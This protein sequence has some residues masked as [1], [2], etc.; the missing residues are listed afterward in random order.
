MIDKKL[1]Y[2]MSLVVLLAGCGESEQKAPESKTTEV[3]K[4][5]ELKIKE[6][7]KEAIDPAIALSDKSTKSALWLAAFNQD[8]NSVLSQKDPEYHIVTASN[9]FNN[10]QQTLEVM[11]S[12][13]EFVFNIS[14]VKANQTHLVKSIDLSTLAHN[15]KG[16]KKADIV[17]DAFEYIQSLPADLAELDGVGAALAASYLNLHQAMAEIGNYFFIK[18]AYSLDD[19]AKA[20][21]LYNNVRAAFLAHSEIKQQFSA[22]YSDSYKEL[23]LAKKSLA[24][25]QGQVIHYNVMESMDSMDEV[26]KLLKSDTLLVEQLQF[27]LEQLE[28]IA[29]TFEGALADSTLLQNEFPNEVDQDQVKNYFKL[30]QEIIGDVQILI[31]NLNDNNEYEVKSNIRRLLSKHQSL[32]NQYIE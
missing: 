3:K 22:V 29:T 6:E 17:K 14:N 9:L 18:E 11:G 28:G 15:F 4:V 32:L 27:F 24:K 19:Y 26:T 13:N 16:Q 12:K 23:H 1:V 21:E 2:A 5:A 25:E 31:K 8:F 10:A 30:F 7:V 20:E